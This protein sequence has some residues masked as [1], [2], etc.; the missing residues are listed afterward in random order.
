MST[1]PLSPL[2]PPPLLPP[3]YPPP[4]LS[5]YNPIHFFAATVKPSY[6]D[7]TVASVGKKIT[8]KEEKIEETVQEKRSPYLEPDTP[9]TGDQAI[10][11]DF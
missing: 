7:N 9:Y 5:P 6:L 1:F 2:P 4:P 8:T 11:L 3:P 10:F